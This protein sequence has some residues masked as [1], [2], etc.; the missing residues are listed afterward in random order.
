M[1]G[2]LY[3][4]P[5]VGSLVATLTSGWTARVRH[6]GR[7]IAWAAAAW[8]VAII[9]FGLAPP[10]W[11]ALLALVAA[12]AAD[13]ISGLF[14]TTLWNQTIPD[15]CG[16]ARR[17]RDDQLQVGPGSR[18][19]RVRGGRRAR[20]GARVGGQRRRALRARNVALCGCCRG[21]GTTAQRH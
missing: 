11:L 20:R 12:G 2:L 8:G 5:S 21:S 4:A 17:D 18:Q 16:P 19:P 1:L 9:G 13:M 6:H 7:A 15:G 10:L 14:R 3:T